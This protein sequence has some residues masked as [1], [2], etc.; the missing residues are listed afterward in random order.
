MSRAR[1]AE[2]RLIDMIRTRVRSYIIYVCRA[3]APR[4]SYN[5]TSSYSRHSAYIHTHTQTPGPGRIQR[6]LVF[7]RVRVRDETTLAGNTYAQG[8]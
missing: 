6:R 7:M 4:L 2:N 8:L 1:P 5:I 3:R